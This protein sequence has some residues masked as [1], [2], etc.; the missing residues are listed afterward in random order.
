MSDKTHVDPVEKTRRE[1]VGRGPNGKVALKQ[2]RESQLCSE[3]GKG[4]ALHTHCLLDDVHTPLQCP[5]SYRSTDRPREVTSLAQ[6]CT[7]RFPAQVCLPPPTTGLGLQGKLMLLRP[8]YFP[9][10]YATC[11][12]GK[13]GAPPCTSGAPTPDTTHFKDN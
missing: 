1:G 6:G 11:K 12:D 4:P 7:M 13:K 10:M 5:C 2:E 8:C 9:D 3:P